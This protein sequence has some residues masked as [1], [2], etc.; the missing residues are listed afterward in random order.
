MQ[1]HD[2]LRKL[3][4]RLHKTLCLGWDYVMVQFNQTHNVSC[5]LKCNLAF[6]SSAWL[7]GVRLRVDGVLV[8]LS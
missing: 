1:I 6:E 2:N 4:Y 7:F 5:K 8:S 3:H